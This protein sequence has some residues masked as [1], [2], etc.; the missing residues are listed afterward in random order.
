MKNVPV[1]CAILVFSGCLPG[2]ITHYQATMEPVAVCTILGGQSQCDPPPDGGTSLFTSLSVDEKGADSRV[3]MQQ[4]VF[5]AKEEQ[6]RLTMEDIRET[7]RPSN[8]CRTRSML[9]LDVLHDDPGFGVR[10]QLTGVMEESNT[11]E[12]DPQQCGRNVPY[13]ELR[14]YRLTATELSQP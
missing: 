8:G 4:E 2:A 1:S 10:Q 12:G 3:F 14:R 6:G 11:T 9:R 13:G 5:P 7:V